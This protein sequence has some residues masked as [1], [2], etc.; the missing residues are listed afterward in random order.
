[1]LNSLKLAII[2]SGSIILAFILTDYQGALEAEVDSPKGS[3][4]IHL[5]APQP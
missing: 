5:N 1:M 3:A 2:V 4:R